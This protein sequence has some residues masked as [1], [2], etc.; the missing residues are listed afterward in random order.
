VLLVFS[1]GD[2]EGREGFQGFVQ[3]VLVIF[4]L[5][6]VEVVD[7]ELQAVVVHVVAHAEALGAGWL[8]AEEA[9]RGLAAVA[10][11]QVQVLGSQLVS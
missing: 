6:A 7:A 1:F 2:K 9:N 4:C 11:A 3:V 5:G 10:R 8:V